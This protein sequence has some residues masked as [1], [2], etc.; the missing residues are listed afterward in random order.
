[1]KAKYFPF[2]FLFLFVVVVMPSLVSFHSF[3]PAVICGLHG[4]QRLNNYNNTIAKKSTKNNNSE[5]NTNLRE[6]ERKKLW[7]YCCLSNWNFCC[8]IIVDIVL[9]W[10]MVVFWVLV[11]SFI[12]FLF[13]PLSSFRLD[14][15]AFE[16]QPPSVAHLYYYL[17]IYF[18]YICALASK[19]TIISI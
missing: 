9:V 13:V 4:E 15:L 12:D 1:M 8:Y 3:Y 7:E 16:P 18:T 19:K 2:I 10:V 6:S 17:F 14:L 11:S 5:S